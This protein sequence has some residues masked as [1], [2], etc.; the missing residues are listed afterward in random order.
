M[1]NT[2]MQDKG[3]LFVSDGAGWCCEVCYKFDIIVVMLAEFNIEL[4][5]EEWSS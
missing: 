5:E 2:F 1:F 3:R 4:T